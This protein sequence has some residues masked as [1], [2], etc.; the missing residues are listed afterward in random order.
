MAELPDTDNPQAELPDR[1]DAFWRRHARSIGRW[2]VRLGGE[3]L[4]VVA[5]V[6]IL[7]TYLANTL[8]TRQS[9][10]LAALQPTVRRLVAQSFD[11]ADA[12]FQ[13]LDLQWVPSRDS[14]LFRAS[15]V[16]V[17]D[18]N[19][20]VVQRLEGLR[21]SLHIDGVRQLR[22]DLRFVEVEGGEVTWIER[23]DGSITAGLGNPETVGRYGPVYRGAGQTPPSRGPDWLETFERLSLRDTT[24]NIINES[25]GLHLVLDVQSAEGRREGDAVSL[26]IA[27]ALVDADDVRG[28]TLSLSVRS[29]DRLRTFS[30]DGQVQ[31]LRLDAVAP[32]SGRF[33]VLRALALPLG[34]TGSGVFSRAD[35]LQALR[36]D[37]NAASGF[38][39]LAG[40]ARGVRQA[41]F[42]ASLDPGE[43]TMT[44]DAIA[45]DSERLS[46]SG[47]GIMRELGRLS[48]GDVGTSPVFDLR[49][50]R[51][52]MDLTPTFAAPLDFRDIRAVGQLDL[53]SRT[54]SLRELR[55]DLSD[56]AIG[57]EG[58]LQTG[59]QGLSRLE[60]DGSTTGP[61]S[62]EQLLSLW[63]VGFGDGARRWIARSV[64]GGRIDRLDFDV[65]LDP[66]FFEQPALTPDRLQVAFDVSEGT[67]RYI[68]TMPPLEQAAASGRIVG[69]RLE[70]DLPRGRIDGVVVTQGRVE[71]PQL[72]PKGGDISITAQADGSTQELLRLADYPPFGYLQRYGV[73]PEGFDGSGRMALTVTR[74]LLEF[75][76][77]DRITYA[78]EGAFSGASAPF[79]LGEHRITDAD[80]T[81]RGGKDGL[82]LEGPAK[83]GPWSANIRWAERY[84]LNGEPTRYAVTGTMDQN[85]LDAFGI[86]LRQVLG[87]A[88]GVKIDATGTGMN[89]DAATVALDFGDADISFADVWD[90]PAGAPATLDASVS[91][92]GAGFALN[93]VDAR[94]DG[95]S[96][97]GSVRLRDD[98]AI[99]SAR[100]DELRIDGV[101]D[102]EAVLGRRRSGDRDLFD[103]D[104]NGSWLDISPYVEASLRREGEPLSLPI[105]LN[106]EFDAVVLAEDYVIEDA[107]MA[108]VDG[109]GAVESLILSGTRPRGPLTASIVATE[110][111]REASVRVPDLSDA[112]RGLYG[113]ERIAGGAVRFDA[114]LPPQGQAGAVVGEAFAT[115]FVLRETPV[116]A[117]LLSLASLQGLFDTLSGDGLAFDELQTSFAL[118]D[119]RLS[120]RDTRLSGPALGLT[121]EGEV[122][123][124]SSALD[125]EGALVPAYTANSLLSDIPLIGDIFTDKD[126]EGV[127]ALTYTAQGPFERAQVAVNPLSALTPGFL[128][129]IFRSDRGELPDA[130]LAEQIDAVRPPAED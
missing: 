93:R 109:G 3:L 53:D 56:T 92:D 46:L 15:G 87:G 123:F 85:T 12:R 35:G 63:P 57:L 61:M 108:Y 95:L 72:M 5:G 36:I 27:G 125:L 119:R 42:A 98:F 75:F 110:A 103:L 78:V 70:L 68:E 6:A 111:G 105:A 49:F 28:G 1:V 52:G 44:V 89:V 45:L 84:G 47:Q 122:D 116:L 64:L 51:A 130:E 76:E 58:E 21:A 100:L 73:S 9:T 43:Q 80:V 99:Q 62:P 115:D 104:V 81:F 32:P 25:N 88:F 127:F 2:S 96:V 19:G 126:G 128:R 30:V 10:D 16:E 67:V 17:V 7:V 37:L 124:A 66:D 71:I 38:V 59:P 86:G 91:R 26:D 29:P 34:L 114:T 65:N 4:A 11:G 82:F 41:R 40:E 60:L 94:A 48:D 55:A 102:G 31:D 107:V 18:R 117:Q 69:N 121:A 54:L 129:G 39:T 13:S 22:P 14:L 90:K 97:A 33:S 79:A 23:A 77:P 112:L 113:V 50:D 8:L 101:V 83:L 120:L 20:A 106:A 24:L 118:R 74:P